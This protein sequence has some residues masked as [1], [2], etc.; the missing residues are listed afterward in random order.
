MNH[1]KLKTTHKRLTILFTLMVCGIVFV[2]GFSMLGA[3]YYNEL[4]IQ[5]RDFDRNSQEI[6]SVLNSQNIALRQLFFN[7]ILEKR[8]IEERFGRERREIQSNMNFLIINTNNEIVFENILEDVNFG[9][10][11]IPE[12]TSLYTR[13]GIIY[14]ILPINAHYGERILF[15]ER[16]SYNGEDFFRDILLLLIVVLIFSYL[17]YFLGYRFVGQSLLPVEENLEDMKAFIHNAGHEL[18]TP[19]A[20]MRGNLQVMQAESVYDSELLVKSLFQIDHMNALIE[21]LREL[22]ELGNLREKT[23]VNLNF[24]IEKI[25]ES[26][27]EM[28]GEKKISIEKNIGENFYISVHPYELQV[29]LANIIKNAILYN[30]IGGYISLVQNKNILEIRDSGKGIS[31][32]EQ[33]MIFE[34]FYRGG[35][36]RNSEEGLGIGLS[37]V[38]KIADTND[39][40][41]EVESKEGEGSVFRVIF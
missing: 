23:S 10:L 8:S 9:R 14:R 30:K 37:L 11:K 15:Y 4:R 1:E 6:Q 17:V 7:Q 18:K 41:I 36:V 28:I 24:E 12:N 33:E 19:L 13:N 26:F 39:W 16:V 2:L 27:Q 35:C 40:K 20:V 38:K 32:H 5:K 21:S 3:K 22:S 29:F 34:R 25:L 31:Q